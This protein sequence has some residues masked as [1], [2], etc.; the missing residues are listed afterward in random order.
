VGT[1]S[2]KVAA[3][4]ATRAAGYMMEV[5]NHAQRNAEELD[6]ARRAIEKY[7]QKKDPRPLFLF[8]PH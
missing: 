8:V 3:T 1:A 4:V 5:A 2:A 7:V 6:R